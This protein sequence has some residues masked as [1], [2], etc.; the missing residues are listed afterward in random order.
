VAAQPDIIFNLRDGAS[1]AGTVLWSIRLALAAG[2]SYAQT[3]PL[4]DIEGSANTAMTLES[5]AAPAA[6][7]FA[8]V[9]LNTYDHS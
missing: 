3:H 1:G 9:V 6:T 8:S 7:N 2:Q 5:A 4:P